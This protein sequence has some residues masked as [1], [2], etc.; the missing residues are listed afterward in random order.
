MPPRIL[1]LPAGRASRQPGPVARSVCAQLAAFQTRNGSRRAFLVLMESPADELR[2]SA[3]RLS[4]R[5]P[6][7]SSRL[8]RT[9]ERIRDYLRFQCASRRV[10]NDVVLCIEEACTN[11][12]RHSGAQS[13]MDVTLSFDG[14]QLTAVVTDRGHGFDVSSFDPHVL[15]DVMKTGGRGLFLIAALVDEVDVAAEGGTRVRMRKQVPLTCDVNGRQLFASDAGVDASAGA[16]D[17]QARLLETLETFADGFVAVDWEWRVAFVNPAAVDL[18]GREETELVGESLWR[19]T[20]R[21]RSTRLED[22]CREAMEQGRASHFEFQSVPDEKWYEFRVY[23]SASGI[24]LY[25]TDITQRREHELERERL[26]DELE[27]REREV[28]AL[29]TEIAGE[30][31]RLD[32]FMAQS[33]AA[34]AYLDLDCTIIEVNPVFATQAGRDRE[35]LIGRDLFELFPKEGA[36]QGCRGAARAGTALQGD[37]TPYDFPA[38]PGRGRVYVDW[39]L[40]PLR[41]AAGAVDG[42]LVT[43]VDVTDRVLRSRYAEAQGR[44]LE[45]M[46]VD[47]D[48]AEAV[49]EA[50]EQ[51]RE[52]LGADSWAVWEYQDGA[53]SEVQFHHLMG[54]LEG[55]R[56]PQA[57]A[58]Y[59]SEVRRTR[60][61]LAVEDTSDS[62]LG[63]S[64]ISGDSG[65]RS[66]LTAP[67]PAPGRRFRVLQLSWHT[68]PHRFAQADIDLVARVSLAVSGTVENARLYQEVLLRQSFSDALNEIGGITVS[69]LQWEDVVRRVVA[70]A[71]TTMRSDSC[72]VGLLQ[73]DGWKLVWASGDTEQHIGT[74]VPAEMMPSALA[75]VRERRVATFEDYEAV[76]RQKGGLDPRIYAPASAVVAP[77]VSKGAAI[78][79]LFF[80]WARPRRFTSIEIEFARGVGN[81]LAQSLD[82]ARLYEAQR[83]IA[84][85]LQ[86][87]LIHHV[88]AIEGMEV[89]IVDETASEPELVGGDFHDVFL[90]ADGRLGVLI[91]DVEGKGIRAAGLTETVRT[92]VRTAALVDP[93]PGLILTRV[94]QLLAD[95]ERDSEFVT[96]FLAVV[97]PRSGVLR[98]ATAGHPPPLV[99]GA[100]GCEPLD[101]PVGPP[102]GS[103]EWQYEEGGSCLVAGQTAVLYTDGLTEAR[104]RGELFGQARVKEVAETLHGR[105]CQGFAEGLRDAA[106][107]FGGGFHDDVLIMALRLTPQLGGAAV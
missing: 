44:I 45:S 48:P 30:R 85:T 86:E 36:R 35:A 56:I 2:T 92:A 46:S 54:A 84:R 101:P 96:V 8:L 1:T 34:V 14:D 28:K 83:H 89:G 93:S 47:V 19:V 78:G 95:E 58:P 16:H 40:V 68:R 12:I 15:P 80:A 59:A 105:S 11:A 72:S 41:D 67:L 87:H 71:R 6:L 103:F 21:M 61:V 20:P 55:R 70:L 60:R 37:A 27:E 107:A 7:D 75:A 31:D 91:G 38:E 51:L 23:P 98:M 74:V 9:R 4:F 50:A 100:T 25:F 26:I 76:R 29:L 49:E 17:A 10:V 5:V 66:V 97:D 73:D 53:W 52:T 63:P 32:L 62:L 79:G 18:L 104:R 99:C 39:R 57:E 90:L 65:I 94:N 88:P 33:S 69:S 102:L 42:M 81:R 43:A 13:D 82:N 77:L 3:P 64:R 24:S 106:L 22:H